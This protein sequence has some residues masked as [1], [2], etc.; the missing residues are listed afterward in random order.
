MNDEIHL[1]T[2]HTRGT[3]PVTS[4]DGSTE[5]SSVYKRQEEVPIHC[6]GYT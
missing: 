3:N 2:E 4:L 5:H 6:L 1:L